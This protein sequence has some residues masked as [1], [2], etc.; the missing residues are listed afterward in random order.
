MKTNCLAQCLATINPGNSYYYKIR[1]ERIVDELQECSDANTRVQQ[2]QFR[3]QHVKP[4]AIRR[5]LGSCSVVPA[6][7]QALFSGSFCSAILGKQDL[8]LVIFEPIFLNRK[9]EGKEKAPQPCSQISLAERSPVAFLCTKDVVDFTPV[10]YLL[11]TLLLRFTGKIDC[12]LKNNWG[13]Q[14]TPFFVVV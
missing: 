3:Q 8:L 9:E 6:G 11:Q 2:G 7:T 14:L 10:S 4:L 5:R 13:N 1:E 12:S